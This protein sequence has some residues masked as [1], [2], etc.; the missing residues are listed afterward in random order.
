VV[1]GTVKYVIKQKP[2]H[3]I[4]VQICLAHIVIILLIIYIVCAAFASRRSLSALFVHV[5]TCLSF[6][7]TRIIGI[8]LSEQ[9]AKVVVMPGREGK[10]GPGRVNLCHGDE[11]RETG[12]LIPD[13]F[14]L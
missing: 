13:W 2:G 1:I 5:I 14:P 12:G 6:S 4:L 7:L 8:L 3:L 10:D 9:G 11:T